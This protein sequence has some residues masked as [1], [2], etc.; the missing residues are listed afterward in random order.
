MKFMKN[1]PGFTL[2]EVNLAIFIMATGV[3]VMCGLYSLGFRENRQSVEDVASAA[4]ADAYLGPLVQGL[5]ATNMP[6]SAWIQI[7]DSPSNSDTT[8]VADGVWPSDGWMSYVQQV[9]T[10][11]NFRIKGTPRATA[12]G[13]FQKIL[14]KVPSPYKG[15]NP[16]LPSDYQY[17]FVATRCGATVQLA[18]RASRRKE[19]LMSQPLFVSEVHFQGDPER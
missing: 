3:L 11:A 15:S 14:S 6:W 1:R 13:V 5:S 18:F 2:L 19:A 10:T 17:G 9:G 8:R 16:G 7:G 4:F 12:D